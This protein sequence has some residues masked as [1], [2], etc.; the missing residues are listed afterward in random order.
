MLAEKN[1]WKDKRKLQACLCY[2]L[3]KNSLEISTFEALIWWSDH[4]KWAKQKLLPNWSLSPW[5][6]C[7][8]PDR[9]SQLPETY[10]HCHSPPPV[11]G[12]RGTAPF[13]STATEQ[14]EFWSRS[15]DR[16]TTRTPHSVLLVLELPAAFKARNVPAYIASTSVRNTSNSGHCACCPLRASLSAFLPGNTTG[17]TSKALQ[18]FLPE[19]LAIIRAGRS[20][21]SEYLPFYVRWMVEV[22]LYWKLYIKMEETTACLQLDAAYVNVWSSLS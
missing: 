15:G 1:K 19:L 3:H 6:A 8:A 13:P 17:I 2:W 14:S 5:R 7:Q 16:S 11:T 21:F 12:L 4:Q 20:S 18:Q 9:H 10:C 22:C